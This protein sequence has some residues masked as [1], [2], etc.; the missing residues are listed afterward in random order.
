MRSLGKL[1]RLMMNH[2]GRWKNTMNEHEYR[3]FYDQVGALNG[4]DFSR[5]QVD[6]EG[7][8]WDLYQEV[9]RVCQKSDLL[10][11]IGTGGGEALLS[12]ADA[13]HLAI[14]IDCSSGMMETAKRNVEQARASQVRFY[15]MNA[16]QL[17]FPDGM[18]NRVTCRHSPFCADEVARVLAG[19]GMFFTQQVSEHDKWNLKQAFG[20]GQ[21]W[22]TAQGTLQRQY[23]EELRT[24]GL[25]DI[26]VY[27]YNATDYYA[28]VQD[29]LFLLRHTPI[30]PNFGQDEQDYELLKQFIEEYRTDRG[31]RTN[32]ARF[33][34]IAHK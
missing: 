9:M 3:Q 13:V 22:G 17:V 32:S 24:A 5:M 28:S 15:Q 11:D 1:F 25:K 6:S 27:E 19:D 23:V 18:F 21:A 26:Q 30:I 31:I 12:I 7:I 29:L 4:W 2:F 34:I 14:G 8:Q 10:L 20:R 33:M 16:E